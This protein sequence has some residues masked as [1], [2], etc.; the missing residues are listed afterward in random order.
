MHQRIKSFI[1]AVRQ[2]H[3]Q[4]AS[5]FLEGECLHFYHILRHVFPEARAYYDLNHVI[6]RIGG[7]YYDITGTVLPNE[8]H[9]P[10]NE[11][12]P[13]PRR[14]RQLWKHHPRCTPDFSPLDTMPSY[15]SAIRSR[16]REAGADAAETAFGAATQIEDKLNN[17]QKQMET[18]RGDSLTI[19]QHGG[20]TPTEVSHFGTWQKLVG[21]DAFGSSTAYLCKVQMPVLWRG[22]YGQDEAQ[23]TPGGDF[24][25]LMYEGG[26]WHAFGQRFADA[27]LEGVDAEEVDE[28]DLPGR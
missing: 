14:I 26:V 3:P 22:N 20:K 1:A 18:Q 27:M 9:K 23:V 15:D 6:T 21:G 5:I 12:R 4:M 8:R 25:Y 11:W 16:G 24:E 2:S 28:S 7:R 17:C 19:E 13:L 10:L